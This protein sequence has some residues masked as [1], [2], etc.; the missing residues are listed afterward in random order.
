[1]RRPCGLSQRPRVPLPS[2]AGGSAWSG[3]SQPP[4]RCF[5]P[6]A[7]SSSSRIHPAW[8]GG[9]WITRPPRCPSPPSGLWSRIYSSSTTRT[10]PR[11]ARGLWGLLPGGPAPGVRADRAVTWTYA[12]DPAL[13]RQLADVAAQELPFT[14]DAALVTPPLALFAGGPDGVRVFKVC[15]VDPAVQLLGFA[16]DGTS[17]AVDSAD[18]PEYRVALAPRFALPRSEF[19]PQHAGLEV[20]A[21]IDHC[22]RYHGDDRVRWLTSPGC[23]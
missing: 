17:V 1:M 19:Q 23:V 13:A 12:G 5:A 9:G 8:S 11:R 4:R 21:C 7:P 22:D 2:R 6:A 14:S 3:T 20:E 16:G 15:K 10:A 18:P